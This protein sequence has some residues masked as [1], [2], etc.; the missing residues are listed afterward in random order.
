MITNIKLSK[1]ISNHF[2]APN[3]T[4][5]FHLHVFKIFSKKDHH[6][7]KI[8]FPKLISIASRIKEKQGGNI[9][10]SKFLAIIGMLSFML[11][12]MLSGKNMLTNKHVMVTIP[13]I[14]MIHMT[15]GAGPIIIT[16]IITTIKIKRRE[17]Q[18]INV[19]LDLKNLKNICLKKH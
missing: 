1:S 3:L 7:N 11:C 19:D 12:S 17:L 4:N 14:P 13:I 15:M 16:A 9:F 10:N 8:I 5:Q 2:L 18:N 6:L